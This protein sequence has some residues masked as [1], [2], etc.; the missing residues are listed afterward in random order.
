MKIASWNPSDAK[1]ENEQPLLP[2]QSPSSLPPPP[3]PTPTENSSNPALWVL[4][5]LLLP[6][7]VPCF[8]FRAAIS[9]RFKVSLRFLVSIWSKGSPDDPKPPQNPWLDEQHI[10]SINTNWPDGFE[11]VKR[12]LH[13]IEDA[14]DKSGGKDQSYVEGFVEMLIETIKLEEDFMRKRRIC[15]CLVGLLYNRTFWQD[16]NTDHIKF[17]F[18][19][20]LSVIVDTWT[21]KPHHDI[22]DVCGR[23]NLTGTSLI[24]LADF[25]C[26]MSFED[27]EDRAL[28]NQSLSHR[29]LQEQAK[30]MKLLLAKDL[31]LNDYNRVWRAFDHVAGCLLGPNKSNSD[32]QLVFDVVCAMFESNGSSKVIK[33][34]GKSDQV[35]CFAISNLF[36]ETSH[37]G[38][39]ALTTRLCYFMV[40]NDDTSSEDCDKIMKEFE[41]LVGGN[42][43]GK[44]ILGILAFT[45]SHMLDENNRFNRLSRENLEERAARIASPEVTHW[46]TGLLNRIISNKDALDIL[47]QIAKDWGKEL[48]FKTLRTSVEPE[49]E[50]AEPEPKDLSV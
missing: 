18:N 28:R 17:W 42:K 22:V 19:E 20:G 11:E 32:V 41:S 26:A 40:D 46:W 43:L 3:P 38:F 47:R 10:R 4:L 2:F 30:S 35:L 39:P 6:V 29:H 15:R 27:S 45:V 24:N 8:Y 25:V 36:K 14:I 37:P 44:E 16:E 21:Q 48:I 9:E 1:L 49:P 7:P 23:A 31:S 50:S 33:P 34:D 13:P 5:L 12:N